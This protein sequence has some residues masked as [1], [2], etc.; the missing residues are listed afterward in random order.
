MEVRRSALQP[1]RSA[2]LP[3]KEPPVP[4]GPGLSNAAPVIYFLGAL[5]YSAGFDVNQNL[6]KS[7]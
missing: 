7:E 2:L 1:G 6:K 4:I 5:I 3:R